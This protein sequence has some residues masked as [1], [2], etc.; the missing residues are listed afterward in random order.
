MPQSVIVGS[1]WQN[2]EPGALARSPGQVPPLVVLPAD[3]EEVVVVVPFPVLV[4]PLPAPV[5]VRLPPEPLE[6]AARRRRRE[7][8]ER[9]TQRDG[10]MGKR[11]GTSGRDVPVRSGTANS[12]AIRRCR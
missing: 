3:P 4:V 12:N 2:A 5:P 1:L 10:A 6:H 9:R 8:V 11:I 7:P